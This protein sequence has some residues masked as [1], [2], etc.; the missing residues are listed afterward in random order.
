MTKTDLK[1]DNLLRLEFDITRERRHK[2]PRSVVYSPRLLLHYH[3]FF[4][5]TFTHIAISINNDITAHNLFFKHFNNNLFYYNIHNGIKSLEKEMN[6]TRIICFSKKGWLN[7]IDFSVKVITNTIDG[8]D[9]R[10]HPTATSTDCAGTIDYR[11]GRTRVRPYCLTLS[12]PSC[13]YYRYRDMSI[14]PICES[15]I[16]RSL[17]F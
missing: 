13:R 7:E 9:I 4:I 8:S 11:R 14:S 2:M 10:V 6:I 1:G 5:F 15:V 3:I 12:D 16:I 17:A